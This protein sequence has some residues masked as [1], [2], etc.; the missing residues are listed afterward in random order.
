AEGGD[1]DGAAG[2]GVAQGVAEQ[3][4]EDFAEPVGVGGGVGRCRAGLVVQPDCLVAEGGCCGA[5]RVGDDVGEVDGVS[6]QVESAFFGVGD[7]VDVVDEAA[8]PGGLL[9]QGVPGVC[10]GGDD[11]V[12]DAFEEAVQGGDRG[13]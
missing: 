8:Q 2:R 10:G 4:V 3:V 13:A 5:D 1:G 12:F 9:A 6:L 11:T 7:R